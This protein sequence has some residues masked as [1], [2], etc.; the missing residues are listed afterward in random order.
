MKK[1][2]VKHMVHR[3]L[4][5]SFCI[6]KLE[7]DKSLDWHGLDSLERLQLLVEIEEITDVEIP[8]DEFKGTRDMFDSIT[9]FVN[10]LTDFYRRQND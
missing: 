3:L 2:E 4:T 9:A 5:E 10:F 8:D 1:S 6:E 7:I